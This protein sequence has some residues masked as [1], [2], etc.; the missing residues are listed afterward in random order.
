MPNKHFRTERSVVQFA[1]RLFLLGNQLMAVRK[2]QQWMSDFFFRADNTLISYQKRLCMNDSPFQS[3]ISA[4]IWP[5]QLFRC[6]RLK[7]RPPINI[8]LMKISAIYLADIGIN[9]DI[10]PNHWVD[11]ALLT[12]KVEMWVHW[13]WLRVSALCVLLHYHQWSETCHKLR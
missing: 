1:R 2:S 10:H 9:S 7:I 4:E 12:L 13:L 3:E 8:Q 11:K 5:K 6:V